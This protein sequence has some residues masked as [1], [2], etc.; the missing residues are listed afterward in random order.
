MSHETRRIG[1][2]EITAILDADI[3]DEPMSDAFPDVPTTELEKA[4]VAFA[5]TYTE[6]DRWRLRIRVWLVFHPAGSLLLDTGLGGPASPAQSWAQQPG[7]LLSE[8]DGLG[9]GLDA[10]DAVAISHVHDDHIGGLLTE[11]G[12]PVCPNARYVVQRADVEWLRAAAVDD[13]EAAAAWRLLETI[14]KA[15]LIDAIDGDHRL[16]DGM[17]LWHLPGHTPGHQVLLLADGSERMVLS[18]DTWNHP[19]QLSNPDWPSGSDHDHAG[20]AASRRSLLAD[21]ETY[22]GALVGPTHFAESF[23]EIRR[24]ADAWSWVPAASR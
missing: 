14:E 15:G 21:L 10:I 19:V 18:A 11:D 13:D 2:F 24:T 20:A 22:P 12:S 4:K 6:D 5:D 7:A 17:D 9:I 8:L 16:G 3:P 23:G 1:R